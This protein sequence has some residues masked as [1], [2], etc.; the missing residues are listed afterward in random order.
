MEATKRLHGLSAAG[1]IGLAAVMWAG[2][3]I[4]PTAAAE[5]SWQVSGSHEDIDAAIDVESSRSSVRATWYLSP[6]DDEVGPYE[7]APFLNRSSYVA[8]GT[9]RM[10]LREQLFFPAISRTGIVSDGM[11]ADDVIHLAAFGGLIPGLDGYPGQSGVDTHEYAVD[12]RY[13]WTGT[14]WYAGAHAHRSDADVLPDL[15]FTQ[16]TWDHE[17]TGIF[18]GRY[19]GPRTTL[20]LGL[21]SDTSSREVSA[22]PFGIN[23]GLGPPRP[24]GMPDFVSSFELRTGTDTETE[25]AQLSV[26]HVGNLGDSM[27]SLSASVRSSRSDT[28]FLVPALPD[29]FSAIDPFDPPQGHFISRNPETDLMSIEVLESERERQFSLSGALFPTQA[30]GVRL[31]LS[32]SDHDT[33]GS[34]DRVGLSANWFFVRNAAVEIELIREAPASRYFPGFPDTDSVAVRV[35]GRF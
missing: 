7:L 26:R 2:S 12:G 6:V 15:L 11:L 5:Y 22:N 8:V 29:I 34:S 16:T 17:S 21:G 10:K 35:L 13:V 33:L 27:F 18:A 14:G 23:P 4:L 3:V 19:F 1:V 28:H 30:L 25:N 20:E 32:T 31:T 9:A 24:P